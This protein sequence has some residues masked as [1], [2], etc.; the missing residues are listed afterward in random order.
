[1]NDFP[2]QIWHF[3][4]VLNESNGFHILNGFNSSLKKERNLIPWIFIFA[5]RSN[6][7]FIREG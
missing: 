7:Q 3:Q 2:C 6:L 4:F 1:M 5:W